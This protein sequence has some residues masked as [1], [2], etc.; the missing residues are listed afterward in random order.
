VS[1]E[2]SVRNEQRAC[3]LD[4]GL[5]KRTIRKA[6][7]LLDVEY[8]LGIR[9]VGSSEMARANECYLGHS[10]PTDVITFNYREPGPA[11]K[12]SRMQTEKRARSTAPKRRIEGDLLICGDVAVTQAL[13]FRTSCQAEIIR[14]AVH[15]ILHLLGFD[16]HTKRA[17]AKM[18]KTEDELVRELAEELPKRAVKSRG[19]H[20]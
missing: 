3:A 2:L 13:E 18:K 1:R 11:T 5:L 9:L 8:V 6:L 12:S 19:K 14:Y 17:R 7:A 4:P 16:D 15:G 20:G 10:G